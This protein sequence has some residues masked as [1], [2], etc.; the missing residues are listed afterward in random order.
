MAAASPRGPALPNWPL[1]SRAW[2]MR[3]TTVASDGPRC[4]WFFIAITTTP[5]VIRE[6][7]F[8]AWPLTPFPET[9]G[10]GRWRKRRFHCLTRRSARGRTSDVRACS[11]GR[12][13]GLARCRLIWARHRRPVVPRREP[14]SRAADSMGQ[15]RVGVGTPCCPLGSFALCVVKMVGSP[16]RL[17]SG[18]TFPGGA[19][20]SSNEGGFVMSSVEIAKYRFRF[21]SSDG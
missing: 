1:Q 17:R 12:P 21:S 19:V 11:D 16:A 9:G 8:V 10:L 13:A 2:R 3:H 15:R 18:I 4:C 6:V 20:L 7:V 14:S 5:V